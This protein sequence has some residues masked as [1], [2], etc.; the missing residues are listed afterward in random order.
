[1]KLETEK[2]KNF[3]NATDSFDFA[4]K[5]VEKSLL[6][7]VKSIQYL[8]GGGRGRGGSLVKCQGL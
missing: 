4:S 6:H 5:K 1:M 2:L 7:I 3:Q 8:G